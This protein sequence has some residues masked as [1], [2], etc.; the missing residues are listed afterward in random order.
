MKAELKLREREVQDADSQLS[1]MR[2]ASKENH[3]V[4]SST[5]E[6]PDWLAKRHAAELSKNRQEICE[7]QDQKC[8]L[9]RHL[10]TTLARLNERD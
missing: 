4:V 8:S 6:N 2:A 1:K 3:N 9:E 10:E 5:P 7:L